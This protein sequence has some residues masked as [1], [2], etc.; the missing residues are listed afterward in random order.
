VRYVNVAVVSSVFIMEE[1]QKKCNRPKM[2]QDGRESGQKHDTLADSE[3]IAT[4]LVYSMQR[5]LTAKQKEQERSKV[6]EHLLTLRERIKKLRLDM[7]LAEGSDTV[8]HKLDC[9][10]LEKLFASQVPDVQ[11]REL[12]FA[13]LRGI[14]FRMVRIVGVSF[15]KA[16]LRGSSFH[17]CTIM[18]CS[19]VAA[20]LRGSRF[21]NCII[22]GTRQTFF[23]A[24]TDDQT[25][26]FS[27]LIKHPVS[28]E[29][30]FVCSRN[31]SVFLPPDH[32]HASNGFNMDI[33]KWALL[34]H[35]ETT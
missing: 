18:D 11:S 17:M 2:D 8:E 31:A 4:L 25:E 3:F 27:C 6:E 23:M 10:V 28:C 16:D 15:D 13:D 26:L 35:P 1:E 30:K 32:P 29:C 24:R 20:D 33:T 9:C 19:F 34:R 22:D 14:V 5:L 7:W 21:H 12:E